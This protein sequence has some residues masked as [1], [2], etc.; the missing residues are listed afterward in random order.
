MNISQHL[1]GQEAWSATYCGRPIAILNCS[2]RWHVYLDH[3]LQHSVVF[4]T[5]DQAVA[6]LMTSIDDEFLALVHAS[7]GR[8]GQQCPRC[9]N[10]RHE[11]PTIR[12][13]RL[14]RWRT[15]VA[16]SRRVAMGGSRRPARRPRLAPMCL[17]RRRRFA[18]PSSAAKTGADA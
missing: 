4:A 12:G 10:V 9:D 6:W 8:N 17:H 3:V 11:Q 15:P 14:R 2:G 13:L 5:S 18:W 1:S 16:T 7:R